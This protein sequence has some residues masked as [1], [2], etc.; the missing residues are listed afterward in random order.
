MGF[1]RE[2]ERNAAYR[3]LNETRQPAFAWLRP[4]IGDS[5]AHELC[6]AGILARVRRM[7]NWADA[8][9]YG[10]P[11]ISA[12]HKAVRLA[13]LRR[14]YQTTDL[15][16]FYDEL[17]EAALPGSGDEADQLVTADQARTLAG[18]DRRTFERRFAEGKLPVPDV[19]GGGGKAHKWFWRTLRP[20][21]QQ[22]CRRKLPERFPSRSC[23]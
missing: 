5:R 13:A 1:L 8:E 23:L 7:L 16:L 18:V 15:A 20:A 17:R 22:V 6:D 9:T 14:K 10:N 4:Q 21:L 19:P 3:H 2:S 11:D 12:E